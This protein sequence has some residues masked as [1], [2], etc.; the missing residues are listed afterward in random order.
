MHEQYPLAWIKM[1]PWKY[2][3]S[4]WLDVDL[5]SVQRSSPMIWMFCLGLACL[6]DQC[7]S[8]AYFF[9]QRH[10]IDPKDFKLSNTAGWRRHIY[11][12]VLS[13]VLLKDYYNGGL[14]MYMS[15]NALS[16]QARPWGEVFSLFADIFL[17]ACVSACA[18]VHVWVLHGQWK[19]SFF[20][21]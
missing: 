8:L 10:T 13:Q 19:G 12:W 11:G 14:W 7:L 1:T 17:T 9:C 16:I 20:W 18:F 15:G 21:F 5:A 2:S 3:I 6:D 4:L